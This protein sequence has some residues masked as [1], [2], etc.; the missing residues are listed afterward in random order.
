MLALS[1][2]N[3]ME[4]PPPP[5]AC[6]W[7]HPPPPAFQRQ[8]HLGCITSC[9]CTVILVGPEEYLQ[10]NG[11]VGLRDLRVSLWTGSANDLQ[12][13][14]AYPRPS[15]P[16]SET[17][18][19]RRVYQGWLYDTVPNLR[20]AKQDDRVSCRPRVTCFGHLAP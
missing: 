7:D 2:R 3:N 6:H 16:A 8:H 13:R 19:D 10:S 18:L 4:D 1:K 14:S 5:N 9:E 17:G 20:R 11:T 15:F 12:L